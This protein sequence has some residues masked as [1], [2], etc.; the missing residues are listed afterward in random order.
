V[1]ALRGEGALDAAA[2][3]VVP[4]VLMHMQGEPRTTARITR[5]A[6]PVSLP[7]R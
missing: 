3:L 1:R 7:R 4:V 5:T 6:L 2:A